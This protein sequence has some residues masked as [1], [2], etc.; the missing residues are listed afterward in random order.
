MQD[1]LLKRIRLR[2][3][4]TQEAFSKRLRVTQG[5]ISHWE[6]GIAWPSMPVAARIVKIAERKG[7]STSIAQLRGGNG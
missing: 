1:N 4:L 2:L 5:A 7:F 3:G 6:R